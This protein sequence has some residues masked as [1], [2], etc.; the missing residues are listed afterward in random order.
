MYNVLPGTVLPNSFG[1]KK[2]SLKQLKSDIKFLE[3]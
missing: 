3:K 2:I 1:K